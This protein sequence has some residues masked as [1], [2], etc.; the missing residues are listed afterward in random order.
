[1]RGFIAASNAVCTMPGMESL[2][3]LDLF[4]QADVAA[5]Q[6]E[7]LTPLQHGWQ[8]ARLARGAGAAPALQL[9]A[10]LHDIGH[11]LEDAGTGEVAA[12]H[13]A[14]GAAVLLPLFGHRVAEPVALHGLAKRCLVGTRPGYRRLLS[15]QAQHRLAAHGGPL[16]IGQARAFLQ[17]PYAPQ[18]IRLRLWDDA[19]HDPA[20]HPPSQAGAL[21]ALL[22]LMRWVQAGRATAAHAATAWPHRI[23]AAHRSVNDPT[24]AV[25]GQRIG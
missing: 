5:R 16:P 14:R 1:M 22:R 18:A 21:D 2:A 24:P 19:A 10:W 20:L 6:R 12:G 13:E 8:C 9:A 3:I 23:M 7:G 15:P 17:R 11:L 4:V 25:H